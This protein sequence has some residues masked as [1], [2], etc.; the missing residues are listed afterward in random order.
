MRIKILIR[1]FTDEQIQ[2][3]TVSAQNLVS[4]KMWLQSLAIWL[5]SLSGVSGDSRAVQY[6]IVDEG[7]D[8]LVD[9]GKLWLLIPSSLFQQNCK[10][11]IP[12]NKG[13]Y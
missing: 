7:V 13:S 5:F 9:A 12:D 1:R 10:P 11:I 6:S 8:K 2:T 3:S 4:Y